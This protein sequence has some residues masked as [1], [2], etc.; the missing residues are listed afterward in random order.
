MSALPSSESIVAKHSKELQ[1]IA[2][3]IS[4]GW[5]SYQ[6]LY[7]PALRARHRPPTRANLVYDEMLAAAEGKFAKADG[8]GV[9]IESRNGLFVVVIG[10]A[11]CVRLKKLD[12]RFRSHNIPTQQA[13][14]F[15]LQQFTLPD[16]PQMLNL[17]AG[18]KLNKLQT[19]VEGIFLTC[20]NPAG[21]NLWVAE[22][23]GDSAN[24]SAILPFPKSP[25]KPK[26]TAG[27]KPKSVDV[28]AK[29]NGESS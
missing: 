5:D 27:F 17:T 11:I 10:G 13:V 2:D 21:G 8:A 16:V 25:Q 12:E 19:A 22:I 29:E 23:G 7:S 3:C 24:D 26:P 15:Q 18:Y 28:P 9:R 20:P 4:D 6:T 1:L 14:D